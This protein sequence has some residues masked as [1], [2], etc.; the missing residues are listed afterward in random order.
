MDNVRTSFSGLKKDLKGFKH[1]L[2]SKLRGSDRTGT[3]ATRERVDSPHSLLRPEPRIA[4]DGH[5]GE[6]GK[7]TITTD[8]RQVPSRDQ[9][10]RPKSMPVGGGDDDRERRGNIDGKEVGQGRSQINLDVKVVVGG[11]SNREV[12]PTH[13]SPS[14]L[15]IPP[16]GESDSTRKF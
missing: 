16:T 1:R 12:D 6:G 3:D 2:A 15:L 5:G 11:G 9:S 14:A 7:I 13:P 8:D 4:A 10:P